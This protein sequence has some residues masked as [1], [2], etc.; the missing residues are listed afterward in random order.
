[1]DIKV[2]VD[3]AEIATSVYKDACGGWCN[4]IYYNGQSV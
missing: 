2:T 1:M 3:G 4:N